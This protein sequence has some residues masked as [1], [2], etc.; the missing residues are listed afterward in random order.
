MVAVHGT[1]CAIIIGG[2][3]ILVKGL[4]HL[5]AEVFRNLIKTFGRTPLDDCA[6]RDTS[7]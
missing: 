1:P 6:L 3:T 5:T 2:F 4:G 7:P